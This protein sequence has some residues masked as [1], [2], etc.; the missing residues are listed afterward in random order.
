MV[1]FGD[2]SRYLDLNLKFQ[3]RV[4][5]NSKVAILYQWAGYSK[6]ATIQLYPFSIY[7]KILFKNVL[8]QADLLKKVEE[9]FRE[10]TT[11]HKAENI[12][13]KIQRTRSKIP[14]KF[15]IPTAFSRFNPL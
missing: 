8:F 2:S 15:K 5:L 1:D 14:F 7:N 10:N 12:R 4:D 11:T 6:K 9:I 3:N 13:I